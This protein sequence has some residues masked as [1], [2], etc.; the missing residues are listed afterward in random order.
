MGS[1][2][3]LLLERIVQVVVH[4]LVLESNFNQIQPFVNNALGWRITV[5]ECPVMDLNAMLV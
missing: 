4:R 1:Y 2:T 5:R 3:W